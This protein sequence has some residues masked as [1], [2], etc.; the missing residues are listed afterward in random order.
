MR[1]I[2][3]DNTMKNLKSYFILVLCICFGVSVYAEKNPS[4]QQFTNITIIQRDGRVNGDGTITY[5]KVTRKIDTKTN[6]IKIYCIVPGDYTCPVQITIMITVMTGVDVSNTNK[7]AIDIIKD[8]ISKGE[9]K[10]KLLYED[11]LYSWE[12]GILHE[13]GVFEMSLNCVPYKDIVR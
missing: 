13:N 12:D 8:K 4:G 2:N 7:E 3:Y 11:I 9:F 5:A 10:G 1:I 6:S